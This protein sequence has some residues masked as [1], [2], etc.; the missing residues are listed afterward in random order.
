[1]WMKNRRFFFFAKTAFASG[2]LFQW[3][4]ICPSFSYCSS[5]AGGFCFLSKVPVDTKI[6]VRE[7]SSPAGAFVF[8]PHHK[9]FL[10]RRHL[11]IFVPCRGLLFSIGKDKLWTVTEL[12]FSSPAGG[13]C[14]L[15]LNKMSLGLA[16]ARF[17]SPAGG[18]CFL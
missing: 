16:T 15:Y 7:F 14:F 2:A 6:W 9:L 12:R 1:M 5:P 8:Y 3:S 17:S 13:F 18:F 11:D 4:H 10:E